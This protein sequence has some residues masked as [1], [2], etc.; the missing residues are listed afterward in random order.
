MA[1]SEAE[2]RLMELADEYVRLSLDMKSQV[3]SSARRARLHNLMSGMIF[4]VDRDKIS[5]EQAQA[6]ADFAS[7]L[8][9]G[10]SL[11]KAWQEVENCR[12]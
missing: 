8:I 2:K 4:G 3:N 10:Q 7:F 1:G 6:I 9:S 11:E 12:K 5:S